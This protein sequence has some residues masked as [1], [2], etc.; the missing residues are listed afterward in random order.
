MCYA[1]PAW[2][3][4]SNRDSNRWIFSQTHGPPRVWI[5]RPGCLSDSFPKPAFKTLDYCS[6]YLYAANGCATSA[7]FFR[8][9]ATF[10]SPATARS[11]ASL[12]AS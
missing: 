10:G 5:P 12:V 1:F 4:N 11:I 6:R 8:I 2:Q 3:E 7:F 9:S